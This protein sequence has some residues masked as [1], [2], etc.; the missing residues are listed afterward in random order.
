MDFFSWN[1][2]GINNSVK[3]RSFRKWIRNYNP[4]FGCLVETH[5][6]QLNAVSTINNILPG[7]VSEENY[8][9]SDLGKL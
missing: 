4:F 3:Q 5:V 8:E 1:V 9:F 2:R 6:Q 7:W